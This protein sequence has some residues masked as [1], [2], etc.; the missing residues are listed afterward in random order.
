MYTTTLSVLRLYRLHF[1]RLEVLVPRV[2]MRLHRLL[3]L[4]YDN[5]TGTRVFY[6]ARDRARTAAA[7]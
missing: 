1:V 2:P 6:N 4:S 7:R 3:A 5:R